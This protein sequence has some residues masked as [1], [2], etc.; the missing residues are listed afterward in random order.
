MAW[1][2]RKK[3]NRCAV[4]SFRSDPHLLILLSGGLCLYRNVGLDVYFR[5][6]FYL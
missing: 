6:R 2:K 3:I 1:E 5:G 4:L